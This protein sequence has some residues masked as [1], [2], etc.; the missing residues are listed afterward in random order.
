[1]NLVLLYLKEKSCLTLIAWKDKKGRKPLV[2]RGARQVGKT[3]VVKHFASAQFKNCVYLNLEQTQDREMFKNIGSVREFE[4]TVEVV[5]KQTMRDGETLLFL[6]E[7]QNAPALISLLRFFY[8]ER[9]GLHVIAA[10]SLLEVQ[11]AKLGL[12][13]PVGRVE[14][15]Y[16][17]PLTFFEF[18]DAKGEHKLRAFLDGVNVN[19]PLP[20][21]LHARALQLFYEYALIGGL[22][23]AVSLAVE[24]AGQTALDTLSSSLLTAY[25][26]DIYKYASAAEVKYLQHVLEQA[27]YFAGERI[28]YENFGGSA[29]RSRE[30]GQAFAVLER[31]MLVQQI[32]ATKSVDLPLVGQKKRAKKILFLDVGLVNFKN[33]IQSSYLHLKDLNSLYR[34]KIAEQLVGQSLRAHSEHRT[35]PIYY[36]AK[37]KPLGAAE[38]DF[39][40]SRQGRLVGIEV[41][42]GESNRL[43]SLV[44]FAAA[45]DLAC[46]MRVWSGA[47]KKETVSS[48]GKTYPLLSVP[49]YL[50]DRMLDFASHD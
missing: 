25:A 9:P 30:M 28:T 19:D 40:V 35:D 4:Q 24:G 2:L 16:L 34:G 45:A 11:I 39:C 43:K 1:M 29:Y 12:A 14:Y 8:E 22:P 42:S 31:T 44:S 36:W 46:L 48:A 47:L 15:A 21:S 5:R 33:N 7:I 50:V 3:S 38:I 49:F 6:D 27:P 20:P 17:Y 18:L 10:G 23:E 41:K 13:M 26:E 37:E 32:E